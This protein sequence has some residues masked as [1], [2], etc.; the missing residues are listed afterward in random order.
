MARCAC[1]MERGGLYRLLP[2]P[3]MWPGQGFSATAMFE[4]S[5]WVM[6]W[7]QSSLQWPA[8]LCLFW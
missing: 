6:S 1:P 8:S 2:M 4:R 3:G 7:Q 5:L